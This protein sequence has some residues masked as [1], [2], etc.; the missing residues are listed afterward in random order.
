MITKLL[1]V[2]PKGYGVQATMIEGKTLLLQQCALG[3][4]HVTDGHS[5]RDQVTSDIYT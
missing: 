4:F 3:K 2:I 1:L 5:T